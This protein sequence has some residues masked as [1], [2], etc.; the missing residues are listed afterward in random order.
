MQTPLFY[1]D[2]DLG[3]E[4]GWYPKPHYL[5]ELVQEK[6]ITKAEYT[7]LDILF[8][9]ENRFTRKPLSIFFRTDYDI[10]KTGLVS[11]KTLVNARRSLKGKGLIDFKLGNS[12]RATEYRILINWDEY[13]TKCSM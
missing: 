10:C 9:L 2:V 11:S 12:H 6:A 5:I 3:R 13:Y 1:D 8:H 7:L 4:K